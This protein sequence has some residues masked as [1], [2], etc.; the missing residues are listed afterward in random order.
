VTSFKEQRTAILLKTKQAIRERVGRDDHITNAITTIEEIDRITNRL[1]K[2]VRGWYALYHPEL[3]KEH[4]D[5]RIFV[6]RVMEY[7]QRPDTS[8]GGTFEEEDLATV[9][10]LTQTVQTLYAQ[11]DML[12]AYLETL[13]Q[14]HAP[15]VTA[16]AGAMIGARLI[17]IAGSLER[18]AM[19]AAGTIQLLGAETALFRH[20]KNR[21]KLAPKHGVIF[22]HQVLQ[23]APRQKQGK[24][25]RVLADCIAIAARVDF[26]KGTF[27]GDTLRKKV[28]DAV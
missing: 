18:L 24:V 5:H 19:M 3:E 13:M 14:E 21:K 27:T 7:H 15:N 26:F 6:D 2:R 20:L 11:R 12:L 28:E 17:H 16:V 8:M 23:R 1:S 9:I 10:A 4:E 22:N 25:A